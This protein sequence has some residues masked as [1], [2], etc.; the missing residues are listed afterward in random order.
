MKR[1]LVLVGFCYLLTLA[2]AVYFG[3]QLSILFACL[4]L[5]GFLVAALI[6]K[7]RTVGVFPV[8]LLTMSLAFGNFYAYDASVVAPSAALAE[9]DAVITG[10]VCE[11]PNQAYNRFYYIIEAKELSIPNAPQTLKIRISSQNALNVEPYSQIKGRVHF[12][13]PKGGEGF[14]S[15]SYYVS[16]GI[17][18]FAYLYE[19]EPVQITPPSQ[20]PLYYYALRLR[21]TLLKSVRSMLPPEEA[22]LVNGVLF[23][24]T[25]SLS[26]HV[27]NDFRTIG[28]SHILSVSGLH[29]ATMAQLLMMLFLFIKIPQKP[30]AA[31]TGVGVLFFMAITC[32]V[33][34]VVRSG[35]MCL[36]Y[37]A[38]IIFSRRPDSLNSLGAAVLLIG[39]INPYAAADIGLLLSFS[40]TLGLI[41]ISAPVTRF[42]NRKT[43]KIKIIS[44]LVRGIN[45]VTAT[46]FGA[47][48][49]T[50]PIIIVSFGNVS[51][52]A[53]AANLLELV[54]STL[55]MNFA[56]IA[57]VLNLIVPHSFLAMPFALAAGLLAKYMQ[58][59][60]HWLAQIPY[61]SISASYGFVRIWLSETIFL[62]AAAV[63][64][65]KSKRR[66]QV[67]AWLSAILLLTGIFTYQLS[68]YNVTRL[69]ILDVGTAQAAVLTRN[70]HAAVIGCGGFSSFPIRSYLLEQG[71]TRL[72]SILL[73]TGDRQESKNAAELIQEFAP[74][75]L[76]M[77]NDDGMD[78]FLEKAVSRA[79]T[80]SFYQQTAATTL[81]N[82]TEVAVQSA[83]SVSA[84]RVTV[85]QVTT[86]LCP[87]EAEVG[88]LPNDW[89]Y[90]DFIAVSAL[91]ENTSLLEPSCLLLSMEEEDVLKSAVQA[92][93][94]RVIVTAGTGNIVLEM[95]ENRTLNIRRE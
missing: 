79:G 1:L 53:P 8:A 82:N 64:L 71:I 12:F 27:N 91:S 61:A 85:N 56:A 57:A 46:T 24:D 30:A 83:G 9:K 21:K 29:M 93:D 28:I 16:K 89:L 59:C 45:G 34:S 41:L 84:A 48:L 36:L 14:S 77:K 78:S 31:I 63:I 74:N 86:L 13:L 88:A 68:V 62:L 67:T 19:Y 43:D 44:P 95:N 66:F 87:N 47:V 81:W 80:V 7:L 10:T 73:L 38:G 26:I 49:F 92:K 60:A 22:A 25:A 32:F 35:I 69:A 65:L 4:C 6:P 33:P 55:M 5:F 52:A 40:A 75:Y 94:F 70:G 90:S 42:L 17:T 23:G 2:A 39:L 51:L 3:R 72:D 76:I 37:L 20:K 58:W 50:L 54:P 18:L 15:R 11:L